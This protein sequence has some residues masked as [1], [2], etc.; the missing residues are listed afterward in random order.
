MKRK[1]IQLAGS[2]MVVSLPSKW[3]KKYNIEKG[4]DIVLEEKGNKIIVGSEKAI[5]SEKTSISIVDMD[6]MVKR[7]LG[8]TYKAGYDEVDVEF[9]TKEL[10]AAQEVIREEFIGFEVVYQ[11]KN[12]LQIKKI[13]SIDANEFDTIFRRMFMIINQMAEQSLQALEKQD[14]DWLKTIMF[15]DKDVNKYADFCRRVLNKFGYSEF[16][17]TP[18]LYYIAEQLERIGD[19]YRD[20][21]KYAIK[22]NSKLSKKT[23]DIFVDV[24][25]FY[26]QF[27]ELFYK[28]DSN[29]LAKFGQKRYELVDKIKKMLEKSEKDQFWILM[30]LYTILDNTFDMNGAL[31]AINV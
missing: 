5:T 14:K 15:M 21:C 24:N 29:K 9:E 7:I 27:Y 17:K 6:P 31:M 16:K 2:T 12:Q 10:E 20:I 22:S 23:K 13:S 3:V 28:Y 8:A 26:N 11:G 1:V 18:P 19:S 4:D 30:Y 25:S